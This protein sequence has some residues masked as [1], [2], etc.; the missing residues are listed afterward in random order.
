M[1][2]NDQEIAALKAELADLHV[3]MAEVLSSERHTVLDGLVKQFT[4]EPESS[5]LDPGIVEELEQQ[6]ALFE[7]EHPKVSA[8]LR[9]LAQKLSNMGI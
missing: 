7:T 4:K 2:T 8:V 5:E 3:S 9:D 6:A 1:T